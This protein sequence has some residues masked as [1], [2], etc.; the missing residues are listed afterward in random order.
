KKRCL[1]DFR[2]KWVVLYFYPKDNTTGCTKEAKDFS[3]Y[4]EEF[5]KL[6]AVVIGIS[7]DSIESHKKFKEKHGLKVILLSDESKETLQK[8]G[9]WQLKKMYGRSYYGVVRSTFL[10]DPDGNIVY[11][12]KRVKVKGHVEDVLKKLK[13]AI[14]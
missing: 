6:N 1:K 8:Y 13:E 12:W 5:E 11:E 4:I 9:V 3:Q 7:P 10:I 14:K 2:G